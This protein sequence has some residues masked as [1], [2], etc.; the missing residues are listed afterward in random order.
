MKIVD[1]N[2]DLV[3]FCEAEGYGVERV[4]REGWKFGKWVVRCGSIVGHHWRHKHD[5]TL[6]I[7]NDKIHIMW[8][9]PVILKSCIKNQRKQN[10]TEKETRKS[11][12][13]N[14]QM[15]TLN[16]W[17]TTKTYGFDLIYL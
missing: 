2:A 14:T 12:G 8:V 16:I 3:C 17:P 4:Q 10:K 15:S 9:S 6:G 13:N 1:E 7:Y 5:F 11:N